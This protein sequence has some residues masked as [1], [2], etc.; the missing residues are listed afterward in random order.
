MKSFQW[1]RSNVPGVLLK[2]GNLK[3]F[4]QG[5]GH[6]KMKEE[7]R[8]NKEHERLPAEHQEE[9]WNY[10]PSQPLEGTN[11]ASAMVLDF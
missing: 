6:V 2:M 4:I 3:T 8:V 10:S 7:I 5:E 9:A 11:L 1:A